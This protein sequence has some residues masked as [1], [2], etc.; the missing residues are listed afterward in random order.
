MSELTILKAMKKDLEL[1]LDR[2]DKRD[3]YD[4]QLPRENWDV[5]EEIIE[6]FEE[7]IDW[8]PTDAQIN[9]LNYC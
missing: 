1:M 8:Q 5:L 3:V 7:V 9:D 2:E 4:E 6:K